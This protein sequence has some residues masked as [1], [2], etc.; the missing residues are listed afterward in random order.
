METENRAYKMNLQGLKLQLRVKFKKLD[1]DMTR[2][3][4]KS[5]LT[6]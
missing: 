3:L 5:R 1:R 4:A 6:S 2:C